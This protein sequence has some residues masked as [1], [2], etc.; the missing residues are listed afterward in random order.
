MDICLYYFISVVVVVVSVFFCFVAFSKYLCA[1]KFSKLASLRLRL[2]N[3]ASPSLSSSIS[4]F[5]Y[6]DYQHKNERM[7]TNPNFLLQ[8]FLILNATQNASIFCLAMIV[9][10]FHYL[11]FLLL[12]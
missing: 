3:I 8:H 9:I 10:S 12:I 6:S 4:F 2:A 1:L 7:N 5:L 11:L